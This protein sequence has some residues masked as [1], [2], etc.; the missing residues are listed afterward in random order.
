M[1]M[2]DLKK[3]IVQGEERGANVARTL[4]NKCAGGDRQSSQST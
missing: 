4:S 3:F 1:E 2:K